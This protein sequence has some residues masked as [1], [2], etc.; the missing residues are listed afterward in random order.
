MEYVDHVRNHE[1]IHMHVRTEW[2]EK[3]QVTVRKWVCGVCYAEG[4][5]M[6]PWVEPE[7]AYFGIPIIDHIMSCDVIIKE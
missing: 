2:H 5:D 6:A 4:A 7:G 3:D 1:H